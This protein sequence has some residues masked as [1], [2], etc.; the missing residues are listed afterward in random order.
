MTSLTL[1]NKNVLSKEH[2]QTFIDSIQSM[3]T[4]L[5]DAP[6]IK[7]RSKA[8]QPYIEEKEWVEA[9]KRN[10]EQD[11]QDNDKWATLVSFFRQFT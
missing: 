8:K 1:D 4:I 5:P 10:Y 7:A 11:V 6:E 9:M 2:L 3:L